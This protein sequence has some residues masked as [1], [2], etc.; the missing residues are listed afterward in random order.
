MCFMKYACKK[1]NIFNPVFIL[2]FVLK[3]IFLPSARL[4]F[5]VM[6]KRLYYCKLAGVHNKLAKG[7]CINF[8][9][10]L[11]QY[12]FSLFYLAQTDIWKEWPV[13]L[14][15]YCVITQAWEKAASEMFTCGQLCS[16]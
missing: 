9:V 11:F 6:Y 5:H 16:Y 8:N 10:D 3:K 13:T 2:V 4:D 12:H 1:N 14:V 15:A 7:I